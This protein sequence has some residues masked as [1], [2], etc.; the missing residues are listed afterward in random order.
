MK[1][2]LLLHLI[3]NMVDFGPTSSFNTERYIKSIYPTPY[4]KLLFTSFVAVKHSTP[5]YEQEMCMLTGSLLP[6]TLQEALL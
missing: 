3:D 4:F 2:H 5:S 6:E 1:I